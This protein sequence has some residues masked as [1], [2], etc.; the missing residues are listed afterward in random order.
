MGELRTRSG[1]YVI[2]HRDH[3]AEAGGHPPVG[4]PWFFRPLGWD[5]PAAYSPGHD[6]DRE[7]LRAAETWEAWMCAGDGCV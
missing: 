3:V 5:S 1:R 4:A 6:S 7:A 2:Y